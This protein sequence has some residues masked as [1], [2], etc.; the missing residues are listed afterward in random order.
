MTSRLG[1]K[2]KITLYTGIFL[3]IA[4][5]AFG[6]LLFIQPLRSSVQQKETELENQQ[7][8]L[9]VVQSR[10]IKTTGELKESS[11]QLQKQIPVKPLIE[12][13][14][15]D[16]EMA[17]TVSNS[18]ILQISFND[19]GA[20]GTENS[21]EPTVE[22]ATPPADTT[23]NAVEGSEGVPKPAGIKE[24]TLDLSIESKSYFDLEKFI[25]TLEGL[26]RI[27]EVKS[28]DFSGPPE[29]TS[30]G[31]DT[32]SEQSKTPFHLVLSIYYYPGLEDLEE[33]LPE[34]ETETPAN[35][36]NPLSNFS[37]VPEDHSGE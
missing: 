27:V 19:E 12:Q 7:K 29:V 18:Q 37:D 35:K 11:V 3:I 26:D 30:I 4:L 9:A 6:Y 22:Q 24:I 17:E 15:I 5:I 10:D 13:F 25:E 1:K 32:G 8:L 16:L 14:I 31:A 20:A 28:I 2:E 23:Q 34:I 33:E 36:S 21:A